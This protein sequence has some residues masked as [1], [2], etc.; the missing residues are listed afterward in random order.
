MTPENLRI[1]FNQ[2]GFRWNG[3][4][5]DGM[6]MLTSQKE[7]KEF[8]KRK[9]GTAPHSYMYY[10][11]NG[12][13]WYKLFLIH[14]T[15]FKLYEADISGDPLGSRSD[16]YCVKDFTNEWLLFQKENNLDNGKEFY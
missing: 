2:I 14:P 9:A 7:I 5:Y 1:F 3:R 15:C 4:I 12:E 6:K 11:P 16:L 13:E 10:R 8:L